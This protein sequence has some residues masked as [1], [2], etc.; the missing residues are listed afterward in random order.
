QQSPPVRASE[1]ARQVGDPSRHSSRGSMT[2]SNEVVTI[3]TIAAGG[4]GVG[5]LSDGRTVFVPRTAPGDEVRLR[6]VR[7]YRRYARASAAELLTAGPGRTAVRCP[8]Y[9]ADRCGG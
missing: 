3:R 8:H 1:F 9:V 2:A 5:T 4:D 6:D 7:V